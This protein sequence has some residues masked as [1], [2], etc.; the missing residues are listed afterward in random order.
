MIPL[1]H[2]LFDDMI[3]AG[4]NPFKIVGISIFVD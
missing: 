4:Y 2:E 1:S 3:E